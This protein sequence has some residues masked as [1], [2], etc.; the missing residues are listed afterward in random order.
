VVMAAVYAVPDPHGGDQVM[1]ALELRP[2]TRFDP[3]A[4]VEF[5]EGQA[6]LGTKWAPR[7]VRVTTEMPLTGT[8][9]VV[10]APLQQASWDGGDVW[11]R[12]QKDDEAY[13]PLTDDDRAALREELVAHGRS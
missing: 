6:D 5:L 10:K 3:K 9:K 1:A 2:A 7:F 11:W 13:R 4:F 8:N 12:P